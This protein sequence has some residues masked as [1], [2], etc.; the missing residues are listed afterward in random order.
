[1]Q[2]WGKIIGAFFGHLFGGIWGAIFGAMLGHQFDRGWRQI[3]LH[4]FQHPFNF[5]SREQ[6]EA[7]F[8]RAT[9]QIMGKLAK[10]DGQIS[11]AEIRLAEQVITQ[12][13]LNATQRA[14]A[15]RLFNEGKADQCDLQARLHELGQVCRGRPGLLQTFLEIQLHAAYADGQMHTTE[16]QLLLQ[17]CASLGVSEAHYRRLERMVQAGRGYQ[18]SGQRSARSKPS[19]ADAYALLGI[20]PQASAAEIKRAYRR[21]LSQHHPDKLVS[22]GLPEEMMQVAARK[23]HEIKQAYEVIRRERNF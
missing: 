22:K 13:G 6:V 14:E 16:D 2:W 3:P 15:I 1:M 9:F 5:T 23:T 19:T 21:L 10:A 8:F 17:I 18:Q 20:A 11:Q 7:I 12:L 4:Q